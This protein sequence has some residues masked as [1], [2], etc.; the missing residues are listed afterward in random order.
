MACSAAGIST[1]APKRRKMASASE[2]FCRASS[3]SAAAIASASVGVRGQDGCTQTRMDQAPRVTF[4]SV[5]GE[6]G[7]T[8]GLPGTSGPAQN[9]G[10]IV[11]AVPSPQP[12]SLTMAGVILRK[13][14]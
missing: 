11:P 4:K 8:T 10:G 7:M 9:V 14:R 12:P 6:S 1:P 2:S 5:F 3:A 13:E